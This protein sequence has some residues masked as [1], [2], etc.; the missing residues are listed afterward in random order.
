M[1]L[2]Y[3]KHPPFGADNGDYIDENGYEMGDFLITNNPCF[4]S[5]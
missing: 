1:I 2:V 3:F 4:S 5:N